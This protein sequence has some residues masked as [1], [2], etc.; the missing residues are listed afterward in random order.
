MEE[1][2]ETFTVLIAKIS[3]SIRKIKSGEM[4]EYNLKSPHV[5]CLYYLYK[6]GALTAK[7]LCDECGEDKAGL[8]RSL[9][10]LEECGYIKCDSDLKKRYR[11]PLSLT[12][13]GLGIGKGIANK[14]DKILTVASAGVSEED[15]QIMYK[16][17]SV[18]CQN[19]E[20][21]CDRYGVKDD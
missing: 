17:L 19:L 11:S 13:K 7:Q 15:R 12:E 20:N 4:E 10:Y 16:G 9:E 18:I 1:R 14:I 8:S 2:F 5:S 21:L 3:R 6:N